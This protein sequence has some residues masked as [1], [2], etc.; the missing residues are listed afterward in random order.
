[1]PQHFHP[2]RSD[3]KNR[4][5][6]LRRNMPAPEARLWHGFLRTL[7]VTVSRQKPLG[8]Y[9]VDFYCARQQLAIEIDGDSHF[10]DEASQY[11]RARSAALARLGIRVVRFTNAEVMRN[12]EGVCLE[13]ARAI[14]V[15]LEQKR[16]P[17]ARLR[18]V[19]PL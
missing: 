1:M 3:L 4:A 8:G 7:P 15:D 14:G 19:G 5:R 11:D 6:A 17:P 16:N 9:I 18:R 2:Y 12:F 13:I 10:S